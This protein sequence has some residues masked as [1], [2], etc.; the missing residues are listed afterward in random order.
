MGVMTPFILF[1]SLI[2]ASVPAVTATEPER[3]GNGADSSCKRN[4][5][6]SLLQSRSHLDVNGE[7]LP[8]S[9]Q[10]P[11]PS[12]MLEQEDVGE[13]KNV[14]TEEKKEKKNSE[15]SFVTEA[16]IFVTEAGICRNK[17]NGKWDVHTFG[18]YC[19]KIPRP[20]VSGKKRP[21]QN[22]KDWVFTAAECKKACADYEPC[23]AANVQVWAPCELFTDQ[24]SGKPKDCPAGFVAGNAWYGSKNGAP[25]A[26]GEYFGK[27]YTADTAAAGTFCYV[28]AG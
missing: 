1:A 26:P 24:T 12:S 15:V 17:V 11:Q 18:A 5:V 3:C 27:E 28:K 20:T 14:Q 13:V 21:V 2:C 4:D 8:D 19:T 9:D 22:A 6:E 25:Q 10:L 7:A 16:G 23:T